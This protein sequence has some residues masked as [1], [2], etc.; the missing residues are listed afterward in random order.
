MRILFLMD[1]MYLH[2]G[3]ERILSQ[4]LNYL[5]DNLNVETYLFTSEQKN[6]DAIYDISE[7]VIWKDLEINYE[8]SL[9]YFHPINL[10][11]T[12]QHYRILKKEIDR[13]KPDV[14]MSVSFS[15]EQYFLPFIHKN[16]PKVKEFHSS[17]YVYNVSKQR[18]IL[19]KSL[20]K[21]NALVVLNESEK[22]FYENKN[23]VVIPNFTDFNTHKNESSEREKTIIAAGRI[24]PVKQ[25]DKLI[26]VWS[27]L[28]DEFPDWK[29][30]IFGSG[31]ELLL[32]EL[33]DLINKLNLSSSVFILPS[34]QYIEQEMNKASIFAM[35]SE[36]E[37]FPM[38]LLEAKACGLPIISF[39]CPTGPRHIVKDME[40]GILVEANNIELFVESLKKMIIDKPLR[41]YYAINGR[42]NVCE[43]SKEIVMK[44]W[45]DF[46]LKTIN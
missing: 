38:V 21:Y 41:D 19:D 14:I 33:N 7:K 5:S 8:R 25:F 35:T 9:S 42:E 46:F 16:I 29:I 12:F 32:Q 2:G 27:K 31:D 40:D 13:I 1:Q 10:K 17:K 30:K 24:A 28:K 23:I 6:K 37:C 45:Y 11:K 4:K 26:Q 20:K 3:T 18:K 15:P 36:T 34:T 44:K 39:D 22:Q 43:F